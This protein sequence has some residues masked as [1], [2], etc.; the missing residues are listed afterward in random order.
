M[1]RVTDS[2]SKSETIRSP[3]GRSRS[4]VM[5]SAARN[6]AAMTGGGSA[7]QIILNRA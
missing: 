7:R 1:A 6:M 3:A 2:Y 5:D 4:S